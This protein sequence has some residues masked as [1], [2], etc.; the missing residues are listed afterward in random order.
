MEDTLKRLLRAETDAEQLVTKAQTER[1]DIIQQ[2]LQE[3]RQ[4]EEQF[5]AKIPEL[6]ARFLEKAKVRATQTIA[7]LNKRYDE[8]KERLHH[9]AEENHQRALEAAVHLLISSGKP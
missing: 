4:A 9:L 2:A 5:K 6:H 7:E 1:E 3:A 8:R